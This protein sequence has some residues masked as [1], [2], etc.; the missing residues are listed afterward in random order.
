MKSIRIATLLLST[1]FFTACTITTGD[2]D[3]TH[4][5]LIAPTISFENNQIMWDDNADAGLYRLRKGDDF[6]NGFV[7]SPFDIDGSDQDGIYILMAVPLNSNTHVSSIINGDSQ[8]LRVE[9]VEPQKIAKP[10]LTHLNNELSWANIPNATS[11]NLYKDNVAVDITGITDNKYLITS[12]AQDGDYTL[13]AVPSEDSRLLKTSDASDAISVAYISPVQLAKPVISFAGNE[14]TWTDITNADTYQLYKDGVA[15]D[16]T[17][18]SPYA[19]TSA[20]QNGKYYLVAKSTAAPLIYEDSEN[21]DE[22]DVVF[23]D[24]I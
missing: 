22:I 7:T 20:D 23:V 12:A 1:L 14:I 11:Y 8:R 13:E 21:S 24:T 3:P 18:I 5:I 9:Y 17:S 19:I 6:L 10:E 4:E 16:V 2:I 15:L